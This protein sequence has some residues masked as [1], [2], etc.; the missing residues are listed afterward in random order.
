MSLEHHNNGDNYHENKNKVDLSIDLVD[1]LKN[2][3]SLEE[4]QEELNLNNKRLTKLFNLGNLPE[5]H[6]I[7]FIKG[8]EY[9]KNQGG[10]IVFT[11]GL[12]YE[13][14]DILS[15]EVIDLK[16]EDGKVKV[17]FVL[18]NGETRSDEVE[19]K[20]ALIPDFSFDCK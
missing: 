18:D 6:I 16:I 7:S 17:S 12:D 1:I 2:M 5:E 8:L 9:Y 19:L 15:G 14:M 4:L 20:D 10:R 3:E 11:G 13:L